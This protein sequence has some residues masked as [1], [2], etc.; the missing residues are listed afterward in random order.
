MLHFNFTTRLRKQ[1]WSF[2]YWTSKFD[3][4]PSYIIWLLLLSYDHG[5]NTHHF[6]LVAF[7][8]IC[9]LT[10]KTNKTS[11]IFSCDLGD[12]KS[13]ALLVN[14]GA[15]CPERKVLSLCTLCRIIIIINTPTLI[16]DWPSVCFSCHDSYCDFVLDLFSVCLSSIEV[17]SLI[18]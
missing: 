2:A 13:L 10:C 7:L 8:T 1:F 11:I 6:R 12:N 16:N 3:N 5:Q 15:E 4:P 17:P 18:K 9:L 14:C